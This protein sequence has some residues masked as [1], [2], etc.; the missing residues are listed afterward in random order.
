VIN[1][2]TGTKVG[3]KTFYTETFD[4]NEFIISK[5]SQAD[6]NLVNNDNKVTLVHDGWEPLMFKIDT[7]ESALTTDV[8]IRCSQNGYSVETPPMEFEVRSECQEDTVILT[9]SEQW[10][11]SFETFVNQSLSSY[12]FELEEFESSKE[13]CPIE[14]YELLSVNT[15]LERV[16]GV[17]EL[18]HN[19]NGLWLTL[20]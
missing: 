13:A 3:L 11:G 20:L 18:T 1:Q 2:G 19:S 8:I 6:C 4:F 9:P 14:T 7:S 15:S 16:A 12:V 5:S 17:Y 10:Q